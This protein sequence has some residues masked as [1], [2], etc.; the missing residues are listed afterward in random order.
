MHTQRVRKA[1]SDFFA[2]INKTTCVSSQLLKK[3]AQF[4]VIVYKK[5]GNKPDLVIVFHL[6]AAIYLLHSDRLH[7]VRI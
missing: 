6:F 2:I 4:L 5:L 7:I 3:L 1:V